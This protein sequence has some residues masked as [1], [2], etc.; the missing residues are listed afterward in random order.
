[1]E[2]TK[3]QL[4]L[5][6]TAYFDTKGTETGTTKDGLVAATPHLQLPW[7]DASREELQEA[8]AKF[9]S[10]SAVTPPLTRFMLA[11]NLFVQ[12]RNSELASR[13][14]DPRRAAIERVLRNVKDFK[15]NFKVGD[16]DFADA[17]VEALDQVKSTAKSYGDDH[18]G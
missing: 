2:P 16:L 6:A 5:A 13:V 12:K 17:I 3:E 10:Y 11:M 18:V 8:F 7:M 9:N 1:M 14:V 15:F 4:E